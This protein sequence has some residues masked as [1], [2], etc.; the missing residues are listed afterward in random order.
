MRFG[1]ATMQIKIEPKVE[2]SMDCALWFVGCVGNRPSY[3]QVIS[4]LFSGYYVY[5][6]PVFRNMPT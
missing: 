6:A 1:I 2:T 4:H 5:I 3:N